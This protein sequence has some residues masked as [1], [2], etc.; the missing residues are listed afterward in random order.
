MKNT[1]LDKKEKAPATA[2]RN[3]AGAIIIS[4]PI[5]ILRRTGRKQIIL[6]GDAPVDDYPAARAKDPLALAIARGY[7]WL[8]LIESGA[9]ESPSALAK[10]IGIDTSYVARL[11]KLTLLAPE[12]VDAILHGRQPEQLSIEQLRRFS[13]LWGEQKEVFSIRIS[14]S[15]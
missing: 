5:K 11:I 13:D 6:P 9:Y 1:Q 8:Q 3:E 10:A 4:V 2:I 7:R 14:K 12:I 15:N